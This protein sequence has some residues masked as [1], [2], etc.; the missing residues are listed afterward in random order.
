MSHIHVCLVS[1]QTIP[2]ILG[3]YHL[4]PHK[5]VFCSTE[6]MENQKRTDAIVNTLKLYGL[7]YSSSDRHEMVLVD[8]DCLEDCEEKLSEV[9]NRYSSN[10]I[11]V[12]LTCGTKI[13]VLGAYNV[14]KGIA[15]R[16]IYTPIPKNEFITVFPKD[17]SCKSPVS[18]D[19][20]LSVQAYVTAY[21][22]SVE[23]TNKIDQ[24][25]S[26]AS[27]NREVCKWMIQNYNAIEDILYEFFKMLGG[28]RNDREFR[29]KMD[30]SFKNAE[31]REFLKRLGM[32][33][34]NNKIE[35]TI[36][37]NMIRFL[38]GD[39]LSDYCY[40]EIA[41][42]AVD[43]CVT[44]IELIS[45]EGVNNEFDVMF[46]KDN[47]LY[48]VECKSLSSKEEKYQD[49]LYKI[50]ALQQD[51]GLRVRGF[52]ISTTRDILAQDGN[53]KP[54][55]IKRAKQCSTEV[56]HPNDIVNIGEFIKNHVR[57][58]R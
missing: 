45:P 13:M 11:V 26:N 1:E 53:L 25:K 19:L 58:L 57:G 9:A 33:T 16:I 22:V 42:L 6:K 35:K 5:V 41:D 30:Y 40:N 7:D 20:K 24:L 28:H 12:N 34:K 8:Q 56:I 50:S 21:G 48:I 3:I 37:R 36:S 43:D 47:A 38:T 17:N 2:N 27:F 4:E 23:N 52:M 46:T 44:E 18:Y 14:F 39:W 49:F 15:K 55:I 31:G 54:H 51:F 10:D 29:L 32:P